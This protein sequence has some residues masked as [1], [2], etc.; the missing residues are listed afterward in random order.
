M[1]TF[2]EEAMRLQSVGTNLNAEREAGLSG[3]DYEHRL[4]DYGQQHV[5]L[6]AM[7]V[8]TVVDAV[9]ATHCVQQFVRAMS[10]SADHPETVSAICRIALA[11]LASLRTHHENLLGHSAE[12]LGL[13]E[14]F[15]HH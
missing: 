2:Y 3:A 12:E 5:R 1:A 8:N 6:A 9:A 14:L 10:A 15:P 7:P 13:S 11:A 4:S